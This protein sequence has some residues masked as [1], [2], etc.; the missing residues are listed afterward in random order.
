MLKKAVV[1]DLVAVEA[2]KS[3]DLQV[4]SILTGQ[5]TWIRS[6]ALSLL[7]FL[8]ASLPVWNED[9]R[10][11]CLESWLFGWPLGSVA[12]G[13]A[14]GRAGRVRTRRARQPIW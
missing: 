12:G 10:F 7:D 8:S 2:E 3:G 14:E 9:E 6:R 1:S 13:F 5:D 11:K 4:K